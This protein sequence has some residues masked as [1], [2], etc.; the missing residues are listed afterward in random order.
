MAGCSLIKHAT[1]LSEDPRLDA[2][3]QRKTSCDEQRLFFQK[4]L[5][6]TDRNDDFVI[7]LSE[8]YE[9]L[10]Y[11]RMDSA[12]R[13]VVNSELE[14]GVHYA[15]ISPPRSCERADG[16]SKEDVMLTVP[17]FKRLCMAI[18]PDYVIALDEALL[19]YNQ[20]LA[21][22][23]AAQLKVSRDEQEAL[24][25]Q[26]E[27]V[28]RMLQ[29]RHA[30][31]D[32]RESI[33]IY[34]DT[35]ATGDDVYN[36]GKTLD[37]GRREK[38]YSTHNYSGSMVVLRQ[39]MDSKLL[40]KVVQ[41]MLN[42]FRII[43]GREWFNCSQIVIQ[44]ALE[45]ALAVVD[46]YV[47]RCVA[48]QESGAGAK[49]R[50]I[51]SAVD[52]DDGASDPV[53]DFVVRDQKAA[54]D[55]AAVLEA[56]MTPKLPPRVPHVEPV[57]KNVPTDFEAFV[58]QT[59]E[60]DDDAFALPAE[61]SGAHRVWG[62]CSDIHVR[63]GLLKYLK[64]RFTV[65][66]L[67]FPDSAKREVLVGVSLKA[68]TPIPP[69]G[70]DSTE[71]QRF[72]HEEFQADHLGRV[73]LRAL[74][75]RFASW[76]RD[77]GEME[78]VIN[79]DDKKRIKAQVGAAFLDGAPAFNGKNEHGYFGIS[80]KG[81]VAQPKDCSD[82]RK[83]VMAIRTGVTVDAPGRVVVFDSVQECATW[84]RVPAPEI[85][86]DM[87][88]AQGNERTRSVRQEDGTFHAYVIR[89]NEDKMPHFDPASVPKHCPGSELRPLGTGQWKKLA[90][91]KLNPETHMV[92]AT[93]E[94]VT[95]AAEAAKVQVTW[96]SHILNLKEPKLC[97]QFFWSFVEAKST[98]RSEM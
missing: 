93:F 23:T 94:S 61:V 10:G 82:R 33:Y 16:N 89:V 20:E 66:K 47:N 6:T 3:L 62:R 55:R 83:S 25:A 60:L 85:S 54:E 12:K 91:N 67:V 8:V 50:E 74:L 41:H 96:M 98:A 17:T 14:D 15:V 19:E 34:K 84:F 68:P 45:T 21:A 79:D 86:K 92:E 71:V 69:P 1:P 2:I 35:S 42:Q 9:L 56:Q 43:R 72:L 63:T 88:G 81:V 87:G 38:Q 18:K 53:P 27:L 73:S 97:K 11:T 80:F 36:L 37:P 49:I 52:R 65:K 7:S 29:R 48:M 51:M 76:K 13:S 90:V 24:R 5:Q 57:K 58:A 26:L 95:A 28:N 70:Q 22:D 78:Y 75:D 40:E 59:C 32:K 46:G 30:D 77:G 4:Y 31:G 39:C 64:A 44:D